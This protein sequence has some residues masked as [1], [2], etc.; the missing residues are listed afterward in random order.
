VILVTGWGDQID[1]TQL[2]GSGVDLVVAKPYKLP[3]LLRALAQAQ[4]LAQG[5]R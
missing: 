5:G 1:P 3:E 4:A 2:T